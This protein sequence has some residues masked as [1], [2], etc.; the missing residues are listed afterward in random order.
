MA[1]ARP[2]MMQQQTPIVIT[3]NVKKRRRLDHIRQQTTPLHDVPSSDHDFR[4]S[5]D[6]NELHTIAS[7]GGKRQRRLKSMLFL[8]AA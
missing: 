4:Y 8:A 3:K 5:N 7:A 1:A 6:Y 2:M